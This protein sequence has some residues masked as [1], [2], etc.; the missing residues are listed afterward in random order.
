MPLPGICGHLRGQP[1]ESLGLVL[2]DDRIELERVPGQRPADGR[3]AVTELLGDVVDHAV[4]RGRGRRQH[5]H[6][7]VEGA[8]DPTDA[9]VVG[10]EVVAPVGDA[11]RLVDDEEADRAL[12]ARHDVGHE[13]LV[14]ES[15]GRDQEDID[16]VRGEAVV[17]G[18]PLVDVAGVDRG[19]PQP[20]A[21]GH[22]DLVAHQR[23][24]RADDEGRAVAAVAADPGRDPV[25]EALAPAGPLDDERA[26]TVLD[27]GFDRLALAVA[28]CRVG[29]EHGLQVPGQLIHIP[30]LRPRPPT[31]RSVA[32]TAR[33]SCA[34]RVAAAGADAPRPSPAPRSAGRCRGRGRPER[35]S[36]TAGHRRR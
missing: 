20:Q 29:A 27:D 21:A 22:R 4:V 17:D 18:V 7:C 14:G 11:V 31:R 34:A 1:G 32:G 25:D 30:S 6:A 28:E 3:R 16:R 5:R 19:G 23:E 26:S 10:P 36:R 24:E 8:E 35:S 12:D 33:R 15:L 9:P 2:E 13:A